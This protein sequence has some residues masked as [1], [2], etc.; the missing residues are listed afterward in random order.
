[1]NAS[2]IACID[3]TETVV[4]HVAVAGSVLVPMERPEWGMSNG[5]GGV[6]LSESVL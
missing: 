4:R 2:L 3:E 5:G 6:A 1:M